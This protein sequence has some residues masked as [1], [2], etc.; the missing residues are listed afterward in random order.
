M[1]LGL[2]VYN[3]AT[4]DL[5]LDILEN[6]ALESTIPRLET[7]CLKCSYVRELRR[8]ATEVLPF[9]CIAETT[10]LRRIAQW[11][12]GC[13]LQAALVQVSVGLHHFTTE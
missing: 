1:K 2:R 10:V 3:T 11:A 5:R 12:T 9:R 8:I 4:R 6:W 7:E 13:Q